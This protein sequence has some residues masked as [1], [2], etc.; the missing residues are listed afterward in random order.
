MKYKKIIITGN[1]KELEFICRI[2]CG[3]VHITTV[4]AY[5]NSKNEGLLFLETI[6]I[7]KKIK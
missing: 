3:V 6:N 4:S 1:E 7:D 2:L 5:H